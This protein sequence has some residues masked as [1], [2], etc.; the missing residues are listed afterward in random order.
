MSASIRMGTDKRTEAELIDL[1]KRVRESSSEAEVKQAFNEI[2]AYMAYSIEM[3]SRQI[4][5]VGRDRDEVEQECLYALRYKVIEDFD[6][7]RGFF[8]GFAVLCL[9]RHLYSI[10]KA[11]KQQKRQVLNESLSLDED[12]SEGDESLSLASLITEDDETIDEALA[13][14]ELG[15]I[16]RK[17]LLSKLSDLEREVWLL[18]VQR[19]RYDEIVEELNQRFP[20]RKVSRKTVDNSLQR[21]RQKAM[22]MGR[23]LLGENGDEE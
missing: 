11:S 20:D 23:R 14:D 6:P 16:F 8:R 18:Y 15:G 2:V 1:V 19:Y 3:L 13:R 7:D 21:A 10:I 4:R 22:S 9:R 5:I 17:R 12:R